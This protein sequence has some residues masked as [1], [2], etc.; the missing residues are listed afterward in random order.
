MVIAC[1]VVMSLSTGVQSYAAYQ[2]ILQQT[3]FHS[4]VLQ[5]DPLHITVQCSYLS[6]KYVSNLY[7]LKLVAMDTVAPGHSVHDDIIE[8]G[9]N[10]IAAP[11]AKGIDGKIKEI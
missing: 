7:S 10:I 8:E 4:L 9:K 11:G 6:Y 1:I 5:S 2:P 3:V